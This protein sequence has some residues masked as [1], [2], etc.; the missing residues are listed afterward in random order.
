MKSEPANRA[1]K[2][3]R[4]EYLKDKPTNVYVGLPG[5]SITSQTGTWRT[6]RP[7]F[8]HKKCTDCY[9]CVVLC[10]DGVVFGANKI[11]EVD[12]TYCKGC[13]ICAEEC[14][15]KDIIMVAEVK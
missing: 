8:L 15:T 2:L 14:P 11:Y 5:S 7:I 9:L 10:P 12:L 4:L 1:E 3:D 6:E 13:G